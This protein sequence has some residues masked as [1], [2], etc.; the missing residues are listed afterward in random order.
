MIAY[1]ATLHVSRELLQFTARLLAEGRRGHPGA[2]LFWQAVLGLQWF[3]DCTA[4]DGLACNHG[5]SQATAYR[6]LEEV[7][8]VLADEAPDLRQTLERARDEGLPH[9]DPGPQDHLR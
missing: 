9:R 3:R 8:A 4:L 6:H 7:I 5:I 1:R 2:D